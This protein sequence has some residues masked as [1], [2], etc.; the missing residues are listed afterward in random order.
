MSLDRR[1]TALEAAND[2][3]AAASLWVKQFPGETPEQAT[4]RWAAEHPDRTAELAR[5]EVHFIRYTIVDPP[6][7][8][9]AA[10]RKGKDQ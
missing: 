3:G 5:S 10:A 1:V 8:L 4:A 9:V 7:W 6:A 2:L